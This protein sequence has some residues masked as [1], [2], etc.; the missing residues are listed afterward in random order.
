MHF[1]FNNVSPQ[2]M[3]VKVKELLSLVR[4]DFFP[5]LAQYIVVK[6]VALEQ[7]FH[8]MYISLL[9]KVNSPTLD[10][11]LLL[12]TY[13]NIKILLYSDKTLA[14]I[15]ERTLLKNL[16][17]WLGSITLAKNKPILLKVFHPLF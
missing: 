8:Q 9:E 17:T 7:N 5:W 13:S 11:Q 4:E 14:N 15:A 10:R 3:D 6:R 2:N 12:E 16:G 1:I